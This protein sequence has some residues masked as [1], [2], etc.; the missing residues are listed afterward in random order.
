MARTLHHCERDSARVALFAELKARG[1]SCTHFKE[2]RSEIMTDYF[3]PADWQGWAEDPSGRWILITD[4]SDVGAAREKGQ[5][6][7]LIRHA[8]AAVF[9]LRNRRANVA[10]FEKIASKDSPGILETLLFVA[11]AAGLYS[12]NSDTYQERGKGA[13]RKLTAWAEKKIAEAIRLDQLSREISSGARE[14]GLAAGEAI[15]IRPSS[16][17]R[18]GFS[19]IL[20]AR[21]P[22]EEIRSELKARGFRWAPK[23][24]VWY[25]PSDSI[26]LDFLAAFFPGAASSIG[27]EPS[28]SWLAS[29]PG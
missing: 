3:D 11:K 5:L 13:A 7:E 2:D 12:E 24:G 9:P 22:A 27:A 6:A 17:G 8:S 4:Y 19:E 16:I 18:E 14:P 15:Q 20:F 28:E 25:G 29:H 1:W 10:L 23:A 26:P 21:K